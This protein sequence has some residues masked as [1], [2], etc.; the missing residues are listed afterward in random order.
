MEDATG[1]RNPS[2]DPR[3]GTVQGQPAPVIGDSMVT[4]FRTAGPWRDYDGE[5]KECKC[6]ICEECRE[7]SFPAID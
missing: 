2:V 1:I 3:D 4:G 6:V 7:A 5:D